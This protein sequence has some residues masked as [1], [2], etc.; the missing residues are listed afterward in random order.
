MWLPFLAGKLFMSNRG[1]HIKQSIDF[2][3]ETILIFTI[4]FNDETLE[5]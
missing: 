2:A 3:H 4:Y 1:L 5:A